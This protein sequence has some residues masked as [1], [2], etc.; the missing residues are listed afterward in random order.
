MRRIM[1]FA[2]VLMTVLTGSYLVLL[3]AANTDGLKAVPAG[4]VSSGGWRLFFCLLGIFLVAVNIR[5]LVKD[6]KAGGLRE[7]LRISTE[8]G[9]TELSVP[10]LEMLILRDLRA[11]P[12]VVDPSVTLKPRGEGKP[13]RC[14]VQLKLRRQRDV[15]KRGDDIKR[16]VRDII[17]QLIPGGLT[18]EVVV[19]VRDI[20]SD[21]LRTKT[22]EPVPEPAGEFNGPVFPNDPGSDGV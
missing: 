10:S 20:V 7:N 8:Q 17:D 22:S 3:T 13:M 6:W 15:I 5:A 21:S 18:V 16:K 4:L 9:M 1:D 2:N 11:E 14:F 12:D 19:D